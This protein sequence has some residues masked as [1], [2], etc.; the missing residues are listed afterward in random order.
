M[1]KVRPV[2]RGDGPRLP[3][4]LRCHRDAEESDQTRSITTISLLRIQHRGAARS[5]CQTRSRI[6][7]TSVMPSA[8]RLGTITATPEAKASIATQSNGLSTK[9]GT[10]RS[11]FPNDTQRIPSRFRS[12]GTPSGVGRSYA[13]RS[14]AP[15]GMRSGDVVRVPAVAVDPNELGLGAEVLVPPQP[16]HPIQ[17]Y[18]TRTSPWKHT[19]SV[20][21]SSYDFARGLMP[22]RD[23]LSKSWSEVRENEITGALLFR[24]GQAS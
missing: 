19:V 14:V 2:R 6:T 20:G 8:A 22:E 9:R 12:R 24:S 4:P 13:K 5:L 21:A 17:G 11:S 18:T 16:P 10:I 23:S 1:I 3:E 15:F 7:A